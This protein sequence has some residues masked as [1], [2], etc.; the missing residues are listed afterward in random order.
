MTADIDIEDNHKINTSPNSKNPL[1]KRFY[2]CDDDNEDFKL[3]AQEVLY[4]KCNEYCLNK[5]KITTVKKDYVDVVLVLKI[6][7]ESVILLVNHFLQ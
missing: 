3:L 1:R 2:Q 4:H 5:K 7:Q 6:I